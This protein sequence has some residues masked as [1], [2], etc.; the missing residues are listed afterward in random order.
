MIRKK[1]PEVIDIDTSVQKGPNLGYFYFSLE[2]DETV[3]V[4]VKVIRQAKIFIDPKQQKVKMINYDSN[5]NGSGAY[6]DKAR[7]EAIEL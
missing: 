1:R 3:N 6:F 7:K 4:N 5:S 2:S